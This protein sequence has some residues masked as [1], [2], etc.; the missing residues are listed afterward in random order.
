VWSW[1]KSLGAKSIVQAPPP[2]T[3][4]RYFF[5]PMNRHDYILVLTVTRLHSLAGILPALHDSGF[6][7]QVLGY[8]VWPSGFRVW[9]RSAQSRGPPRWRCRSLPW[10]RDRNP[11]RRSIRRSGSRSRSAVARPMS[12]LWLVVGCFPVRMPAGM[13]V[14]VRKS[15]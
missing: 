2:R 14:C 12:S 6:G 1:H 8:R 13:G 7:L 4:H 5:K 3:L 10:W 9:G 15:V 11:I